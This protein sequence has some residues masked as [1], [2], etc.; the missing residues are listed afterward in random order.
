MYLYVLHVT[1]SLADPSRSFLYELTAWHLY[2]LLFRPSVDFFLYA[3]L[4]SFE[5]TFILSLF[6]IPFYN[7]LSEVSYRLYTVS[8]S[9]FSSR[10]S[11]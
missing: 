6:M 7:C 9:G 2:T 10:D 11:L 5:L 8:N 1:R 4:V 3:L